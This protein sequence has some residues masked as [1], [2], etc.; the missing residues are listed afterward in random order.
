MF[1][2]TDA[3][4][5]AAALDTT[6]APNAGSV[7]AV[8]VS[9]ES[10]PPAAPGQ[11]SFDHANTVNTVSNLDN[12]DGGTSGTTAAPT[13]GAASD[14]V[15]YVPPIIIKKVM[16]STCLYHVQMVPLYF[17]TFQYVDLVIP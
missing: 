11:N 5:D 7:P 13:V 4:G 6:A 8:S 17:L 15:P 9:A 10:A 12:Q 14:K 1:L 3:A 2:V 16:V